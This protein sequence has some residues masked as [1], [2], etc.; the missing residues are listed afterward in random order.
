M[1]HESE[2]AYLLAFKRERV[3]CGFLGVCN[4]EPGTGAL[5]P[6]PTQS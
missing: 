1:N 5:P 3:E 2:A 4:A 6:L